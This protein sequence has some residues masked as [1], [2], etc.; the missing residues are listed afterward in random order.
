MVPA[1][2]SVEEVPRLFCTGTC[3]VPLNVSHKCCNAVFSFW[4]CSWPPEQA[5]RSLDGSGVRQ[6][7]APR[8]H[9]RR[10]TLCVSRHIPCDRWLVG[11]G[12]SDLAADALAKPCRHYKT[13]GEIEVTTS[14]GPLQLRRCVTGPSDIMY[15][16]DRWVHA[17]CGLSSF[18]IGVGFIGSVSLLPP[19]HQASVAG[20]LQE[21]LKSLQLSKASA[22][23]LGGPGMLNENGL[24]PLHWAAWNGHLPLVALLLRA[25]EEA[26]TAESIDTRGFGAAH[27]LRWATARG[28]A[29]VAAFLA[30]RAGHAADEQGSDRVLL[31]SI[32]HAVRCCVL[33]PQEP[34]RSIGQRPRGTPRCRCS[35]SR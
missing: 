24:L 18:N 12:G 16:P 15:V 33:F 31:P 21:A 19:L 13:A 1:S 7:A 3:N 25:Q 35:S 28:H 34:R 27:A 29:R 6:E 11:R 26:E 10:F 17:T 20:D 32:Q 9:R 30:R 23:Q 8:P 4:V 5:R 22:L 14:D 2:V